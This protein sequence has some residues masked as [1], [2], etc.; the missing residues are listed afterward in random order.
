LRIAANATDYTGATLPIRFEILTNDPTKRFVGDFEQKAGVL[1]SGS[2]QSEGSV[3]V[4]KEPGKYRVLLT[5]R[6]KNNGAAT[7][8]I[9]FVV[10][11]K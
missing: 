11:D 3:T 2:F 4:P 10:E 6:D 9:S 7:H 8:S 1:G 5:T